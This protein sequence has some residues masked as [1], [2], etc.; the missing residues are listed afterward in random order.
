M[1]SL[2]SARRRNGGPPFKLTAVKLR[3][4]PAGLVRSEKIKIA[5][6]RKL[7]YSAAKVVRELLS[8]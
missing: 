4:A 1:K 7:T 3:L 6:S 5:P 2:G 8:D